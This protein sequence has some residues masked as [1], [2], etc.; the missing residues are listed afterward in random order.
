MHTSMAPAFAHDSHISAIHRCTCNIFGGVP[1]RRSNA[2]QH[3]VDGAAFSQEQ[4]TPVYIVV[5]IYICTTK[6]LLGF[7]F[8]SSVVSDSAA[9][10]MRCRCLCMDIAHFC[11]YV[12]A[13][14]ISITYLHGG[15]DTSAAPQRAPAAPSSPK[16]RQRGVYTFVVTYTYIRLL[17]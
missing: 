17:E 10:S 13:S 16:L 15:A 3:V 4:R 7:G 9:A 14:H 6:Q 11:H 5:Y 12:K 8:R 2:Q 1:L